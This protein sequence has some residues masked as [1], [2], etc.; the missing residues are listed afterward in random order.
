MCV[1][2]CVCLNMYLGGSRQ[3]VVV[4]T[5]GWWDYYLFYTSNTLKYF[6]VNKITF[7]NREGNTEWLKFD[8]W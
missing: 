6:A 3:M 2:V 5:S 1:C 7:V 4:V 8:P